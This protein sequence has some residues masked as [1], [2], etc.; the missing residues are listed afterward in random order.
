M[1]DNML[2]K[3]KEYLADASDEQL[4]KDWETL[5]SYNEIGPTAD[6]YIKSVREN[7]RLEQIYAAEFA[8]NPYF[9]TKEGEGP[10]VVGAHQVGFNHGVE[11]SEAHPS[12]ELVD[13]II[14]Q[15]LCA[16]EDSSNETEIEKLNWI[17]DTYHSAA[18]KPTS[19]DVG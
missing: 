9:M 6:E 1:N 4:K 17:M 14:H 8:S 19:L 11:W 12:R 5:K 2:S 13:R 15:Y 3:L 16:Y 7:N 18:G 10:A